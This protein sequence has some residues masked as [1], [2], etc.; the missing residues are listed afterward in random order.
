MADFNVEIR[1]PPHDKQLDHM[2]VT[3]LQDDVISCTQALQQ[4]IAHLEEEREDRVSVQS[5]E[6]PY[7]V[8]KICFHAF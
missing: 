1:V 2:T 6:I 8:S 5:R 3:G 7:T 4:Q